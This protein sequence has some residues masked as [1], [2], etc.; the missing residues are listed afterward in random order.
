MSAAIGSIDRKLA[1]IQH[2][3]QALATSAAPLATGGA[4]PRVSILAADIADL[5]QEIHNGPAFTL[6]DLPAFVNAAKGLNGPGIDDRLFLLEKLLT[7]MARLPTDS[8]FSH[9]LQ[10]VVI[11][12]LYKDL[13]HPPAS[14]LALLPP[15]PPSPAPVP[16]PF[17]TP[18]GSFYNILQPAL[19][20]AG[21]PYARSVPGARLPPTSFLPDPAVV[22]DVLLKRQDEAE[23]PGGLA[24]LFFA[25]ADLV[26]H[27]IF[28]TRPRDGTCNDASSYLD[29]SPLY[30]STEQQVDAVRR[31][32]GTGR[33]WEDVFADSRLLLMPPAVG[34]LLILFCRNH[35]Y[36]AQRILALNERGTF[37][38]PDTLAP[39][40]RAAQ[41]DELFARARL[42]N[43]AF[44]MRVVLG[45]YVG[46]ILGLVRDGLAWRLNPLEAM[47]ELDHEVSPL[48]QG[49]AVS[50]EFNLMYRWHATASQADTAWIEALFRKVF[51]GKDP[52]QITV[53]DFRKEVSAALQ[54]PADVR[55][56]T[57][58]EL[59]R[60]PDGRYHDADLANILHNATESPASAFR[61]R[62]IP[63][64]F[65]VIEVLGI[66]QARQWGAC[67]LNE[68]R[69]FMGLRPYSTFAEWNPDPAI[70]KAAES[71]YHDIDHLEL[72][73]GLQ[74]EEA[75][76]PMPGAGLCPGYTISRAILADAVC[77]TRG[78]RFLTVDF[79]P[80]NLTAWGFQDCAVQADDG[81]YGGMLTKLLFRTLPAHYPARSAYAHFPFM[82]PATMRGYLARLPESP[83][84]EYTWT[85][86]PPV[87]APEGA[88]MPGPTTTTALVRVLGDKSRA[89]SV[90]ETRLMHVTKAVPDRVS[91]CSVLFEDAAVT[92]WCRSFSQITRQLI[93]S[94]SVGY[95][96][97]GVRYVDVVKNV[98]NLVPV[99]WIA[100]E[101]VGLPMKTAENS[102]G[103][104]REHEL[105]EKFAVAANY[106]YVNSLPVH[107]WVL[108]EGASDTARV[109]VECLKG[110]FASL[111]LSISG[112]KD[113]AVDLVA[114]RNE[115]C[116]EFLRGVLAAG[117]GRAQED[118]LAAGLFA[119]VV[120]TAALYSRALTNVVDYYLAGDRQ[121]RVVRAVTGKDSEAQ[122]LACIREAL[123]QCSPVYNGQAQSPH[124]LVPDG[125]GLLNTNFLEQTGCQVLR[126][127]FS[128]GN[129]RRADKPG[130][131]NQ[132]TEDLFGVKQHY[133]LNS[134][135]QLT[136]WPTSM[137]VQYSV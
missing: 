54:P 127:I 55:A 42:V 32:D 113:V 130:S 47:R 74:A 29:L 95:G 78:D 1:S 30:G 123:N 60:G 63:E 100:N 50:V 128:L 36:V 33:L 110:H 75:K 28:N 118:Q 120:A 48:G 35:N 44:F 59:K 135:G 38:A 40:P 61:A 52:G 11:D 112:I 34:A 92:K 90:Y 72:Y 8:K 16:Y 56:W 91:V 7:L 26:I 41:D 49:N 97:A 2:D 65:R 9:S 107:E 20:M 37:A 31:K 87:P 131:L 43:A 22:F 137:I 124:A 109:V 64:V 84:D 81:S 80:H 114:G 24:S 76:V 121:D 27:S 14:F 132:I 88:A 6:D 105:F 46:A 69:S 62:G 23:H 10:Q 73:V 122:T 70:H 57:F 4:H 13:P 5:A 12:V 98:I 45:D 93:A 89:Q 15:P 79:T 129:L 18:D 39:A 77:L 102:R 126:E 134:K 136:P 125:I 3:V 111:H 103:V 104:Y 85:R 53:A 108:R 94:K 119:E 82:V 71:L 58:D 25:F 86:P 116:D 106:V 51:G 96:G 117:R 99:Y 83:V 101:I 66:M 133:Y 67:S 115:H 68:F 17:R 19:G 21:A